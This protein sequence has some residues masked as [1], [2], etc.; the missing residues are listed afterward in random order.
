MLNDEQLFEQWLSGTLSTEEQQAIEEKLLAD[1]TWAQRIKTA[2]EVSFYA[3]MSDQQVVPQWDMESTFEQHTTPWWQWRGLPALSTAFSCAALAM[4]IFNVEFVMN[5]QGF[6]VRFGS[7]EQYNQQQ[8]A[9]LVQ[10]KLDAFS[11]QQELTL[12]RFSAEQLSKQQE[13]NL[14]L[15]SYIL[16]TSRQERKED[17][18]DFI[19]YFNE[20]RKDDQLEFR[21]RYRQLEDAIEYQTN[22]IN[23]NELLIQPA[24]WTVE[25]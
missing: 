18:S 20:Q 1:P 10:D 15:A 2:R 12:T 8:V 21:V 6:L 11:Q 17:M 7:H 16:E 19:T 4:V 24:S 3:S 9:Q 23:Q 22:M 14:Q 13:G 5:E 25:E